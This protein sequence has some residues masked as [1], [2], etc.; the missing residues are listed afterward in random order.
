VALE[1]KTGMKVWAGTIPKGE[2]TAGYASIVIAE[3]GGVKQYITLMA[4][5]LISF[6]AKDGK[7]LWRYGTKKDRFG[8]N[9]AN[10]PTPIIHGEYVF[11][12]TGYGNRGAALLKITKDGDTFAVEEVYWKPELKNKH[13]GVVLVGDKVFGDLDDSG[14]P[15]CAD[16]KTGEVLWSRKAVKGSEGRGSASLTYADGKLY[17]RY[18]NGWTV[19]VDATADK[20]TELGAFKIA[21]QKG[22]AWAHPVVVG[23][24]L[25]IRNLDTLYC[26]NVSAK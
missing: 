9:T 19:L 6:A 23:G 12:A 8:G 3:F 7:M 1:K 13:G 21:N 5:G 14:N 17:V 18:A 4:N 15:W 16:F 25:Y 24:K 26:Y 20:Y 22:Q 10:I 2:D 11:A